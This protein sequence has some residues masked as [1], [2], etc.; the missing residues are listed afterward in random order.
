M[1][2]ATAR[3]SERCVILRHEESRSCAESECGGTR[4]FAGAHLQND[5]ALANCSDEIAEIGSRRARHETSF[6]FLAKGVGRGGLGDL[7][8]PTGVAPAGVTVA[9]QCR[10]CTGFPQGILDDAPR[11]E[12]SH[13]LNALWLSPRRLSR[14]RGTS[15]ALVSRTR[16]V[17]PFDRTGRAHAADEA[18]RSSTY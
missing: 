11:R 9:G 8:S 6:P 3:P 10:S 2:G 4:F 17:P 16:P 15:V 12:H 1:A 7:T 18:L 13:R 5:A 14:Q